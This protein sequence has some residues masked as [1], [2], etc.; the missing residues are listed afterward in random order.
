M[1]QHEQIGQCR[2]DEQPVAVLHHA[3]IAGLGEAEKALDDEKGMLHL[4]AYAGLAAILLPLPFRQR[5]IAESPLVGEV[6]RTGRGLGDQFLLT[7]IGRVAVYSPLVAVQQLGKGMLV[8]HVGRG[9]HDRVDQLGFA[10]HP[11][12]RFL[13]TRSRRR[14]RTSATPMV[15]RSGMHEAHKVPLVALLR[16]MHLGVACFV[17]ILGRG[18]RTDDGGIHDGAGRDLHAAGLQVPADFLEQTLA[19]IMFLQQVAELAHGGFV[20]CRFASQVNA[21]EFTHGH[22]VVER[23]FHRR[24]GQVEPV[25][26]KVDTQHAFETYA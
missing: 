12:M 25:L 1:S 6:A 19:Q 8:M 20:R 10:V 26:E 14:R 5:L 21:D 23:F 3:A 11:D 18:R 24:V 15:S 9:G 16:L 22:R 4:G 2:H 7:G 17:L 13:S